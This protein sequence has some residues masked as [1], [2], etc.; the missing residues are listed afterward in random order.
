MMARTLALETLRHIRH[1]LHSFIF[2]LNFGRRI[3]VANPFRQS[4]RGRWFRVIFLDPLIGSSSSALTNFRL[5][6]AMGS[7]CAP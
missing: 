1:Q 2:R 6:L 7:K 3:A 4:N 5:S